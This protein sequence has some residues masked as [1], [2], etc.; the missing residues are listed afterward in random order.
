MAIT[1]K[2]LL[3]AGAQQVHETTCTRCPDGQA[4]KG[5]TEVDAGVAAAVF[6]AFL[7]E[8]RRALWDTLPT[9]ERDTVYVQC[10]DGVTIN[11]F[12]V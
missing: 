9:V 11:A 10:D 7:T 3:R 6:D 1:I 12:E 4:C 8:L 2:Q 5:P